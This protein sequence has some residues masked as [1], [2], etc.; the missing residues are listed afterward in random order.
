MSRACKMQLQ[1]ESLEARY[2]LSTYYVAPSGVDAGAGNSSAPWRTLQFAADRVA[3]GDT[4]VVRAGDY[5]G[6]Y[7]DTDGTSTQRITFRGE[8]GA[9]ITSRNATTPDGINLEGADYITIEGF[10]VIN[11]PRAGI[12][13]VLNQ[14][15]TIRNNVADSNSRWGIFTGFSNDLLIEG[16]Q[17]SNSAIEHGIYVSNSSDRPVI[18]GNTIFGNRSNGIHLNGDLSQGSF[19]LIRNALIENNVIYNNGVGGGSAINGDGLQSSMIRNNLIYNT[20]ASGISLYRI[21]GAAGA[22]NNTVVNNTILVASTGRWALNITDGSTG[23]T[24]RNNILYNNNGSRGSITISPDSLPGFTSDYNI[25]VDRFT[26]TD[27]NTQLSLSQWRSSTG[28][29]LHSFTALPGAI[30]VSFTNNNYQLSPQSVAR[31]RGTTS[32]APPSDMVG[33]LRPQGTGI[34]I[35]AYEAT[36]KNRNRAS[37][38]SV[39]GASKTGNQVDTPA[40]LSRSSQQT[41]SYILGLLQSL[42]TSKRGVLTERADV[43]AVFSRL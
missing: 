38:L 28:Q 12:R 7:L 33:M 34:D 39:A 5:A 42:A 41:T 32:F 9:R 40:S 31:D 36:A 10:Q 11:Q 19:G 17:T 4:V 14:F 30:F 25:V 3:A 26:T 13:S 16:N 18:R 43:D 22:I 37:G 15:V 29:D 2:V 8:A 1:L 24:V 35:G 23:N 21:D 20:K 6:F 27:G